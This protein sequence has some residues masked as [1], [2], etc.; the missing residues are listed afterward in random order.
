V[1]ATGIIVAVVG[2]I[3]AGLAGLVTW[4]VARRKNSGSVAT[5]DAGQLWEEGKSIRADM[6]AEIVGLRVELAAAREETRNLRVELAASRSETRA[7]RAE[8]VALRAR[9]ATSE[10]RIDQIEEETHGG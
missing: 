1:D 6:R 9:L 4:L 3:G 5:S 10:G 8:L 2:A 7:L